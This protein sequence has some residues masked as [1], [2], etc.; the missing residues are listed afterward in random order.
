M[1]CQ[2]NTI[3]ANLLE[4]C[5]VLIAGTYLHSGGAGTVLVMDFE[6]KLQL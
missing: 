3:T 4:S 2:V 1:L 6:E 5:L